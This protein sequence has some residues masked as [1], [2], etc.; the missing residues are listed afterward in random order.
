MRI[1]FVASSRSHLSNNHDHHHQVPPF[2]PRPLPSSQSSIAHILTNHQAYRHTMEPPSWRSKLLETQQLFKQLADAHAQLATALEQRK[3]LDDFQREFSLIDDL[4][5]Q[6][7]T[8]LVTLV[9]ISRAPLSS[10]S[11]SG[12]GAA[13]PTPPLPPIEDHSPPITGDNVGGGSASLMRTS[14]T[15]AF[16]PK[17]D[18]PIELAFQAEEDEED[19]PQSRAAAAIQRGYRRY[20]RN[21][22]RKPTWVSIRTNERTNE[23][24][25]DRSR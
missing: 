8:A 7:D 25:Q 9:S 2:L 11:S 22:G 21:T 17:R 14:G 3:L 18:E 16:S 5:R 10:S 4:T 1:V 24:G 12:A 15:L 23:R 6:T 19:T 20:L 13:P